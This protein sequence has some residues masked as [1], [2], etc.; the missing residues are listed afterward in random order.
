[1]CT[2]YKLLDQHMHP[3]LQTMVLFAHL[4]IHTW[5]FS[6]NRSQQ[7]AL[8]LTFILVNNSTCFGQTCC[9]SG[10][11]RLLMMDSKSVRNTCRVVYQNKVEK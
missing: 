10:V 9:P 7:D 4:Y 6:Y 1:M 2:H 5:L 3:N 11:I 8:F